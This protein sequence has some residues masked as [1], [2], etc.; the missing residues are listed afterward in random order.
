MMLAWLTEARNPTLLQDASELRDE[1]GRIGNLMERIET[2]NPIHRL[3]WQINPASVERQEDR[4]ESHRSNER[5]LL[6]EASADIKGG[7]R[8]VA[9][10]R[11]AVQ[12]REDSR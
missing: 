1:L 10:N 11:L 6:K 7:S 3:V 2:H 9:A 5:V 8:R 4:L 12:L